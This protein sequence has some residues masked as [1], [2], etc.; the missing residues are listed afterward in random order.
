MK[1]YYYFKLRSQFVLTLVGFLD[2]GVGLPDGIFSHQNPN[3]GKL[4]SA[5]D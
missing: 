3:S 5:L 1:I 2:L 4:W